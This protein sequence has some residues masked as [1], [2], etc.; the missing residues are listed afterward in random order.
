[1]VLAWSRSPAPVEA[2]VDEVYLPAR[3]GTLQ[4]ALIAAAR[5]HGRVPVTVGDLRGLLAEVAA[6]R[7]LLVLQDLGAGPWARWHYA[8]VVGYD[9]EAG[10]I[11][12]HSGE[13]AADPMDLRLFER[14][15]SRAGHWALLVLPPDQLPLRDDE[16]AW[17]EALAGLERVRPAD[18]ARGYRAATGRWPESL[19]AW[20]GLGNARYASGDLTGAE[21]AFARA[22]ALHPD[23]GAAWN[24]LAQVRLERGDR[25]GARAAVDRA[26]AL[27][28]PH[29]ATFEATR[30]AIDAG[31]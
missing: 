18:A 5:G 7:P 6:G 29:R 2:L 23:S 15:W 4:P 17:L 22:S 31:N 25:T 28:G 20:L 27:G 9:L 12:L 21:E 19:A 11:S 26:L 24:N 14:T 30:R 16:R 8:V 1:M 10:T 13:R 3:G